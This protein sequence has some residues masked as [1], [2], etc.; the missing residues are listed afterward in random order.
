MRDIS[1]KTSTQR[2]A[3]ATAT[4][5]LSAETLKRLKSGDLPKGDPL[6][7]ARVAA[8]QAAKQTS[9]II[10]YCHPVPVDFADCQFEVHE[11]GITITTVVKAIYKTGV[12]MEALTAASVAALTI[13]DMVKM[14]DDSAEISGVRL[15]KKTGGKSEFLR[16]PPDRI[17]TAV[18]VLSD[19]RSSG[20]K[21]DRSGK[22]IKDRLVERDISV[23]DFRVI[24]DDHERIVET[25]KHLADE[26]KVDLVVTTGGTGVGSRDNTPEAI[27]EIIDREIPGLS[28]AIRLY[29][30]E[31]N[32]LSM[33]SRSVAGTRGKTLIISFPGS[34]SGVEDAMNA[35]MP[36]LLHAIAMIRGADHDAEREAEKR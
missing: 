36:A 9:A 3:V 24:P 22:L 2:T 23:E 28:E 17:R 7:I 1:D 18:V 31:R 34:V 27:S 29:G 33:L 11:T 15:I 12:E 19:S 32:P 26:L 25:L 14:V 21:E 13:Y 30:F 5:A 20:K 4:I 6:P 35:T 10:P 8:I 16:L